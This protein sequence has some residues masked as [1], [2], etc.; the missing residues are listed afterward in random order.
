MPDRRK[1]A[2]RYL[3]YH[4]MLEIRRIA[5]SRPTF[6][7]VLSRN[8]WDHIRYAGE[9]ADWLHN[10]AFYAA[11]DFERFNEAWFWQECRR[12]GRRFPEF[13]ERLRFYRQQFK[14]QR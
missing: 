3:L 13:R 14:Q 2:Y 10:L 8:Q 12:L 1:N 5:W 4:A 9:V 11:R 6:G 7:F